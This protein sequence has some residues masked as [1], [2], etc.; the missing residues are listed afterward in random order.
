MNVQITSLV[1]T[2]QN[3]HT[4]TPVLGGQSGYRGVY[5]IKIIY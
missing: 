4:H 3:T 1:V 2:N 5:Y